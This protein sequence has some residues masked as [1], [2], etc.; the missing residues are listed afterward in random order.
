MAALDDL[1]EWD[2]VDWVDRTPSVRPPLR[3]Y[4][5][6]AY[7]E[8]RGRLVLFGGQLDNNNTWLQDTWEY[9]GSQWEQ[10]N[11]AHAPD[12]SLG[13]GEMTYDKVRAKTVLVNLVNT[14]GN[15]IG[16][17][18]VWEWDGSDWSEHDY[19]D[20]P[21]NQYEPGIQIYDPLWGQVAVFRSDDPDETFSAD[22]HWDGTQ[23]TA[24]NKLPLERGN[25]SLAYDPVRQ[26]TVLF[27]GSRDGWLPEETWAYDGTGWADLNVVG[28]GGRTMSAMVYDEARAQ[29]VL[30]GGRD[31]SGH[32][33]SDTWTFDGTQWQLLTPQHQ[34]PARFMH[35]LGYD[36]ARKKVILFGG[37][38][39]TSYYGPFTALGD[40]WEWD[41]TDWTQ[42]SPMTSPSP[43]FG[44]KLA[45]D[46]K[47]AQLVTFG[48]G[49]HPEYGLPS[50]NNLW[51]AN[52]TW[53]FDG[54]EWTEAASGAGP[55]DDRMMYGM[56]YDPVR[57]VVM[58]FG[59]L[60][61]YGY[62]LRDDLQEWDGAQWTTRSPA[63]PGPFVAGMDMVYDAAR[64]DFVIFGGNDDVPSWGNNQTWLY[65]PP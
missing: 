1:W 17:G 43:R 8:S 35:A 18:I 31:D 28:P 9:D 14:F 5:D 2:G 47:H 63:L 42:L 12:A 64:A 26:R 44:I 4:A 27:G 53:T 30:F 60:S 34:P 57:E 32:Y 37:V 41:G 51:S 39:A 48:G 62:Q 45:Y 46:A 52:D 54:A 10:L 58:M 11:P 16:N 65:I 29:M 38:T 49:T 3:F 55:P 6:Q 50:Q 7:D 21:A 19:Y 25:A 13:Y 56:A 61:D 36:R 40:T 20:G 33:F 24:S 15:A 59:G 23:W 22:F